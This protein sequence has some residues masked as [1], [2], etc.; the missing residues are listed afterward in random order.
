MSAHK[1]TAAS[2]FIEVNGELCLAP[3][4]SPEML[5]HI[6]PMCQAGTSSETRLV[7]MPPEVTK[8]VMK[9]GQIIGK[10]VARAQGGA[11]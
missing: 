10:R 4:E 9:A 5:V 6:L 3:I 1:I 2:V 8:L 7:K 11:A